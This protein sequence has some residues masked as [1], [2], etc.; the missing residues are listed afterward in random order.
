MVANGL[1]R[2][3]LIV[4]IKRYTKASMFRRKCRE[5]NIT[6]AYVPENMMP[7]LHPANYTWFSTMKRNYMKS[8][9]EW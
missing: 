7:F 1:N 9:R 3:L 6:L 2:L 4:D 8:W 5:E